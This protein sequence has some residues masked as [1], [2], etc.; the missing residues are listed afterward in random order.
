MR[1][2]QLARKLKIKPTEIISFVSD[3]FDYTINST[4]NS[5]VPKEYLNPI[6]EHFILGVQAKEEKIEAKPQVQTKVETI[7]TIEGK[8]TQE[9]KIN[10]EDGV[11]RTP[12]IEV[13]GVK[14]VGKIELP[15]KPEIQ[16]EE[17]KE[18]TTI[19]ESKEEQ[20]STS[21]RNSKKPK[22]RERKEV[23]YEEKRKLERQQH[24]TEIKRKKELEKKKRKAHYETLMKE[25][26]ANFK[27]KKKKTTTK[28]KQIQLRRKME[29]ENKPTSLWGKFIYWL[30][31]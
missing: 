14:V 6:V 27:P 5:I 12:K 28:T 23:N 8:E 30:N 1:L 22:K 16:E 17:T 25:K 19:E 2:A 7:S 4:P 10:L 15:S 24:L 26:Q 9:T 13:P 18:K 29:E 31:N 20:S 3:R 11:I 21:K